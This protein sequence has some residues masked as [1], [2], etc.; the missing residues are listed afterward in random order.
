MPYFQAQTPRHTSQG[1][2]DMKGIHVAFDATVEQQGEL[3]KSAK[4]GREWLSVAVTVA[5]TEQETE[6]VAISAFFGEIDVV[7]PLLMAGV[8]VYIEGKIRLQR[9]QDEAGNMRPRL[10]VAASK[11]EPKGLIGERR[12]KK[13]RTAKP[14]AAKPEAATPN[15]KEPAPFSDP[16]P[17]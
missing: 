14:E 10:V 16:L 9:W 12:P 15:I 3:R 8:E 4:T 11:I 6:S 5:T 13:P 7:A 17:F 1:I 2:D